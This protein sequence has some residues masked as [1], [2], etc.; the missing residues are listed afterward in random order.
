MDYAPS[1]VLPLQALR[2]EKHAYEASRLRDQI[3]ARKFVT[4]AQEKLLVSDLL[5]AL[6]SDYELRGKL[7][8][9][10]RSHL[11]HLYDAFGDLSAM[12]LTEEP[13]RIDRYII[14]RR[15]EGAQPAT[16]NRATQLLRQSYTLAMRR[17][18]LLSA[19]FV[20]HLSEEGNA[21]RGF[22]EEEQ[23]RAVCARLPQHLADFALYGYLSGWRAGECATQGW[24]DVE[25][26]VV[27]SGTLRASSVRCV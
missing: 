5:D 17:K 25:D 15:N 23:F 16:I 18:H 6:A 27:H 12:R 21:R 11:K 7:S 8:A 3:G 20:R 19:P 22:F 26:D 24:D 4:P 9:P 1:K 13:E 10:V 14:A 2:V